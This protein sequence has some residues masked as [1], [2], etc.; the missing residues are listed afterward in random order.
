MGAVINTFTHG[1]CDDTSEGFNFVLCRIFDFSGADFLAFW[2]S[3]LFVIPAIMAMAPDNWFGMAYKQYRRGVTYVVLASVGLVY[4]F[5]LF[6]NLDMEDGVIQRAFIILGTYVACDTALMAAYFENVYMEVFLS[7]VLLLMCIGQYFLALGFSGTPWEYAVLP[8]TV[9][10]LG[11]AQR[12]HVT[13]N[14]DKL[15]QKDRYG[16]ITSDQTAIS[17]IGMLATVILTAAALFLATLGEFNDD[18]Y[19]YAISLFVAVAIIC[20]AMHTLRHPNGAVAISYMQ[21]NRDPPKANQRLLFRERQHEKGQGVAELL[22][23]T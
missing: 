8:S 12:A 19:L 5:G 1:P 15:I 23:M 20:V 18:R 2:A 7:M 9:A 22:T 11:L 6:T 16:D 4:H 17:Q 21:S 13:N 3:F 14:T 10:L